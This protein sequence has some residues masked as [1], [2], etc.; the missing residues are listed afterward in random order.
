MIISHS[1]NMV[2]RLTITAMVYLMEEITD[3]IV[4]HQKVIAAFCDVRAFDTVDH[5]ILVDKLN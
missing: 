3:A 4:D 1:T 2:T 5:E